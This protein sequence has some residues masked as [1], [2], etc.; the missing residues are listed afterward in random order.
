MLVVPWITS[1][2]LEHA[3]VALSPTWK[4]A[5]RAIAKGGKAT[6]LKLAKIDA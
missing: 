3:R 6:T 5:L 1:F 4:V 2:D